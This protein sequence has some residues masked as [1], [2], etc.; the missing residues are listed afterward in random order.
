VRYMISFTFVSGHDAEIA[1]LISQEQAYVGTLIEQG[2]IEVVYVGQEAVR[3]VWTVI[4]GESKEEI[5]KL[6][7]TFPLHPYMQAEITAIM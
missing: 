2:T 5:Q 3:R 1:A 4:K 6:V 7:E